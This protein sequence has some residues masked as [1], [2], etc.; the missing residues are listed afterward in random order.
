MRVELFTS[1]AAV[2]HITTL[3]DLNA[4]KGS[5]GLKEVDTGIVFLC[6]V[7]SES[8]YLAGTPAG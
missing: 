8:S 1:D 4:T 7:V 6:T 5:R 2:H 3:D